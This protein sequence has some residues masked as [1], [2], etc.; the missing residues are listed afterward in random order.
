MINSFLQKLSTSVTAKKNVST[1]IVFLLI[2]SVTFLRAIMTSED[3]IKQN[4]SPWNTVTRTKKSWNESTYGT[5]VVRFL[6]ADDLS[7]IFIFQIILFKF[8]LLSTSYILSTH[9]QLT[10]KHDFFSLQRRNPV[11][12]RFYS[13]LRYYCSKSSCSK[14]NNQLIKKAPSSLVLLQSQRPDFL[15]KHLARVPITQ[16]QEGTLEVRE[17]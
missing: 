14:Y 13:R 9:S 5:K 6:L 11:D 10:E 16:N 15:D 17:K 12:Y 3:K 2:R 4:D 1:R 8:P 7:N